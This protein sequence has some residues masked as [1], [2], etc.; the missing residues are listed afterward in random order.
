[1]NDNTPE[2]VM[3]T[4]SESKEIG[5]R[6]IL[7]VGFASFFGGVSQDIFIP[8]LPFYLTQILG[9]DKTLVGI[10]EGLVS[11][12]ASVFKVIAGRLSDKFGQQKP[13]IVG[14]YALSMLGRGL[15]ALTSGPFAVFG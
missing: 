6:N 5:R 2:P 14:G 9:F 1:M 7:S 11:A 12:A 13:I 15:L 10:A 4:T 8:I 3:E